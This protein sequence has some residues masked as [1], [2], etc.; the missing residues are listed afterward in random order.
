M[1]CGIHS[2]KAKEF[3]DDRSIFLQV[4]GPHRTWLQDI[5]QYYY[6]LLNQK[7]QGDLFIYL[8]CMFAHVTE[9]ADIL[10][11]ATTD[12]SENEPK[13]LAL[14]SWLTHVQSKHVNLSNARVLFSLTHE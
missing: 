9:I 4:T 1:T 12:A 2:V 14:N 8:L 3:H 13:H 7:H 10:S 11:V 5:E 6:V